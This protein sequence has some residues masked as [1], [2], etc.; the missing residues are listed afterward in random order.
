MNDVTKQVT[1]NNKEKN[2]NVNNIP[3]LQ[4]HWGYLLA[5]FF[6]TILIVMTVAL[7]FFQGKWQQALTTQQVYQFEAKQKYSDTLRQMTDAIDKTLLA[8]NGEQL[9]NSHQTILTATKSL[10]LLAKAEGAFFQ[11]QLAEVQGLSKLARRIQL[12][13][14]RN[15]DIKQAVLSQLDFVNQSAKALDD[16]LTK[17]NDFS[18]L[19]LLLQQNFA[20]IEGL[21]LNTSK[22]SFET[23]K[24]TL[25]NVTKVIELLDVSVK[26]SYLELLKQ[27]SKLN[28]LLYTDERALAKWQGYIRLASQYK[29]Q[30]T[31]IKEKG[32]K[33]SQSLS[34]STNHNQA[35]PIEQLLSSYGIEIN[36]E[37]LSKLLT[38]LIFAQVFSLLLLLYLY[39]QKVQN[40]LKKLV[41]CVEQKAH[42]K[43]TEEQDNFCLELEQLT[44]VVTKL[45]QQA[46]VQEEL[47]SSVAQLN[48]QAK[49]L[50]RL[51][52]ENNH[53]QRQVTS[54]NQESR[55]R[56][57][58]LLSE[59]K[60]LFAKLR[61]TITTMIVTAD[62][63]K[64]SC[65]TF[66]Q[67]ASKQQLRFI[68]ATLSQWHYRA[69]L[70]STGHSLALTDANLVNLIHAS[71]FNL[72][73]EYI[74]QD[75]AASVSISN[76]VIAAIKVD[77][78]L[79]AN[80]L[81][82]YFQLLL[83]EQNN[84][85]LKLEVKLKDKRRGQ[86][87]IQLVGKVITKQRQVTLP[88]CLQDLQAGKED[89]T[90][91]LSSFNVLLQQLHGEVPL[92]SLLDTGYQLAIEL[93]LAT[94][95][96]QALS[97][98]LVVERNKAYEENF[99]Q[100]LASNDITQFIPQTWQNQAY[101]CGPHSVLLGVTE[102]AAHHQLLAYFT[103]LG[104]HVEL[105][106][107]KS[108]MRQL[109]QTGRYTLLLSEFDIDT[110]LYYCLDDNKLNS[111]L[112]RG[113]FVVNK[114]CLQTPKDT[115]NWRTGHFTVDCDL[116]ELSEL[117]SPWLIC[118]EQN[119]ADNTLTA[120]DSTTVAEQAAN[121]ATVSLS[122]ASGLSNSV[123]DFE[124]YITHQANVELALFMLDDY[125]HNIALNVD[126]LAKAIAKQQ[127]AKAQNAVEC[128]HNDARI[129][130]A[131][132]LKQLSIHWLTLLASDEGRENKALIKK[133]R[134]KTTTEITK[135][136]KFAA[137]L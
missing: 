14:Q 114:Q 54:G 93:P 6:L 45:N 115:K 64:G 61:Q 49:E 28:E 110:N 135:L 34:I 51:S 29:E 79:L 16:S 89:N 82:A 88:Q 136:K 130:A 13:S 69:S 71:L 8:E 128:I 33:V 35:T 125:L 92:L 21:S 37:Q 12:H 9:L 22:A 108:R 98:E 31:A 102:P 5:V 76:K 27:S 26:E 42:G 101:H 41:V 85:Q 39:Y 43:G 17:D 46:H 97:E 121:I 96:E 59:Y 3:L 62:E 73:K 70:R 133:L 40:S 81:R 109:W 78:E 126:K 75:N 18:L 131:N 122:P 66:S 1:V 100:L 48:E 113:V 120:V 20:A 47:D 53:L 117:L 118:Q 15:D 83:S 80:F 23:V 134:N 7:Q 111:A 95:A 106:V 112:L 19:T 24:M 91:L 103:W 74:W 56:I 116:A 127:W 67:I 10:T 84:V 50:T 77:D 87:I 30:L 90:G 63:Q 65:K 4:L 11:A 57:Q 132:Q 60:I 2:N 123:L 72:S 119:Q 52:D 94:V 99:A 86:Q 38:V 137:A 107:T 44:R 105:V 58:A 104:L 129:L 36:K 124:R 55:A 32:L 25:A 68:D